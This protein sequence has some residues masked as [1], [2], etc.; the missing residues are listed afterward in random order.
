MRSPKPQPP[1][2]QVSRYAVASRCVRKPM[3][4]ASGIDTD[5]GW[6]EWAETL[7]ID[8]M[9]VKYTLVPLTDVHPLLKAREGL[10][11]QMYESY[12]RFATNEVDAVPP[13]PP[14]TFGNLVHVEATQ[15]GLFVIEQS[16]SVYQ[17]WKRVDEDQ[18]LWQKMENWP[19]SL[20]SFSLNS[21]AAFGVGTTELGE[22]MYYKDAQ[23]RKCALSSQLSVSQVL[24]VSCVL[25]WSE[26]FVAAGSG[27]N[28]GRLSVHCR[29]TN[30]RSTLQPNGIR[31][32]CCCFFCCCL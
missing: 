24:F 14:K 15:N 22:R 7:K 11:K 28:K 18:G 3:P 20:T 27:Q 16:G 5:A 8:P 32:C 26:R 13:P 19:D 30:D 12:A 9:P 21:N 4:P 10:F 2:V 17:S 6:S 29:L 31:V 25:L 1:P 23:W